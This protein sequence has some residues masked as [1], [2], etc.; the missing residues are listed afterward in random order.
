MA[1]RQYD[2]SLHFRNSGALLPIADRTMAKVAL[3]A[4]RSR[5]EN[6]KKALELI[7]DELQIGGKVLI[8]P[9]LSALKNAYANSS[10][11][12]VEGVIE[13]LNNRFADLE[14]HVGESSGGAYLAGLPTRTVL[15][16]FGFYELEKTFSNVHV[17]DLD[18][19]TDFEL[20]RVKMIY[21]S[22]KVRI[23]KHDFDHVISVSLPKTHDFVIAT[24]GIKNIMG[25]IHRHDRIFI[26]GLRG[27]AF[28]QG[29]TRIFPF[30]PD[31]LMEPLHA[32]GRHIIVTLGGYAKSVRLT[33]INLAE[34]AKVAMPD[35]VVLDGTNG[36]EG[37]GPIL[38]DPV[39]LGVAVASADS[40][41][42]DGV[43]VRLMGL[44]P[45][46]IGY[47]YYLQRDGYGD[48]SLDGLVGEDIE[49]YCK[50]FTMHSRY[51]EQMRWK[52]RHRHTGPPHQK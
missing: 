36:M 42:A 52:K 24:M 43:G 11:E 9:N 45:W 23:M 10:P 27:R 37:E 5:K 31:F 34:Y 32:L 26:H 12:A 14:I 51:K 44:N 38:G 28:L 21:R 46:D 25:M 15:E 30:L 35:L 29:G 49:R 1:T 19:W 22:E 17:I 2:Y 50:H 33:N 40:V 20:M 48:Y 41:K 13:F 8:K 6:I 18:D 7:S 39:M 4:G 16:Y 3:T 47:L